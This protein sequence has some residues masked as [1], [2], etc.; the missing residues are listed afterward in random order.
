M[1]TCLARPLIHVKRSLGGR[2]DALMCIKSGLPM[3]RD[4]LPMTGPVTS[5][6]PS[7]WRRPTRGLADMNAMKR[8]LRACV[9][10]LIATIA[11]VGPVHAAEPD[12]RSLSRGE[13]VWH[14][15]VA[16]TGPIVIVVSL[17]EQRA[18]VYRNGIG[19]GVSTI[20]SGRKGHRTPPG[21]FTILQKE[22][23]HYSNLYDSAPMP[24]MERLTWDGVAMHGG[25]LPGYPASHGCI[26]LPQTFAQKL[27]ELTAVGATVVVADRKTAPSAVV[28]PAMLA[29]VAATG[30][31]PPMWPQLEA[32]YLND[33]DAVTGPVSILATTSSNEVFVFQNGIR[34][35]SSKFETATPLH[36]GGSVLYVMGLGLEYAPS[37]L[38]SSRPKHHWTAYPI[39]NRGES[40]PQ[41]DSGGAFRLPDEFG[42]H[43]YDWLVPGSTVLV[44]DLPAVRGGIDSTSA[45]VLE[46]FPGKR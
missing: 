38:D 20:S 15:E 29:P 2:D 28:H 6:L 14:P 44:T 33:P 11:A 8:P 9:T 16:P 5:G 31:Q 26:R 32:S 17:D 7:P 19:I 42:R 1:A 39:P 35:A 24:F 22:A 13:Y 45:P 36:V 10:V 27:F 37:P 46:S 25:S 21:I 23:I 3:S 40:Q 34:I 12:P 30:R 18:Y 41:V 4:N 43:L